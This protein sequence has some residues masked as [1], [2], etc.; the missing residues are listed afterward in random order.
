[1]K[2]TKISYSKTVESNVMGAGVW[3]KIGVDANVAEG[4]NIEGCIAE[5]RDYVEDAHAKY[6]PPPIPSQEA[7]KFLNINTGKMEY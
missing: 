7:P 4:E 2:I 6:T 5:A 3:I 1:M